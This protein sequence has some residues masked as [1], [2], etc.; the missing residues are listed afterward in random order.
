MRSRFRDVSRDR[1]PLR[2]ERKAEAAAAL[3]CSHL[4]DGSIRRNAGRVRLSAHLV[5]TASRTTLWSQ[6]Y[7]RDLEDIFAVQDELSAS[8]AKALDHAFANPSS[9]NVAPAIYD[10][11]L[12]ASLRSYA[13]DE[14]RER[15]EML[16]Q[17]TRRAPDFTEAW[18]RLAYIRG[19]QHFYQPFAERAATV[20]RVNEE[21]DRALEVDPL[22]IDAL[23]G[24]LFVVPAFGAFLEGDKILEQM[25]LL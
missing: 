20:A 14:L 25:L 18:A 22:N 8:I 24:Q 1:S 4:L 2:G 6:R 12:R 10:L 16:E 19:W 11:Y 5:E 3:N 23:A 21:A 15:I 7:D 13:P 9:R 17:V